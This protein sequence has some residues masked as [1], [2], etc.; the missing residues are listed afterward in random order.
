MKGLS[1][2]VVSS[3]YRLEGSYRAG[4][5]MQEKGVLTSSSVF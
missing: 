5:F 2:P 4:T 3:L 1:R